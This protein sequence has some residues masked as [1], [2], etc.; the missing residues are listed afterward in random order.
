M[1]HSLW[2]GLNICSASFCFKSLPLTAS[3][4]R[5]YSTLLVTFIDSKCV[6]SQSSRHPSNVFD[7]PSH[8]LINRF[9]KMDNTPNNRNVLHIPALQDCGRT[10]ELTRGQ[11]TGFHSDDSTSLT[12]SLST[13]H[14]V[15]FFTT[16]RPLQIT[17]YTSF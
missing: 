17:V 15:V 2:C 8:Q 4:I 3:S 6:R 5:N 11:R 9:T 1:Q 16:S 7:L 12:L 14:H 10:L 13:L